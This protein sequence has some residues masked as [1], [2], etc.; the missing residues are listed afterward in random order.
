MF[1]SCLRLWLRPRDLSSDAGSGKP[2]SSATPKSRRGGSLHWTVADCWCLQGLICKLKFLLPNFQF[3]VGLQ[4]DNHTGSQ[5][6]FGV[7]SHACKSNWYFCV[8]VSFSVVTFYPLFYGHFPITSL[9]FKAFFLLLYTLDISINVMIYVTLTSWLI[10]HVW[11]DLITNYLSCKKSLIDK[12]K[13]NDFCNSW[14]LPF[15]L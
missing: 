6:T 5:G 10:L 1:C 9:L 12:I 2:R 3:V 11:Y 7:H 4:R 8:F 14:L 13:F 15:F